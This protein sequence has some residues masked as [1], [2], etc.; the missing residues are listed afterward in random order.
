MRLLF[1]CESFPP[2]FPAFSPLRR[3]KATAAGFLTGF[4][5]SGLESSLVDIP[6]CKRSFGWLVAASIEVQNGLTRSVSLIV[7]PP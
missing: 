7:D 3:P 4:F 1:F 2:G 6:L 5:S